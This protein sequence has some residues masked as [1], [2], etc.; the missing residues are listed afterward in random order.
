MITSGDFLAGG[1]GVTE[2]MHQIPNLQCRWVLN[3]DQLAIKTN[4]FNHK[5]VKHFWADLYTQD[6]HEMDSV[7]FVWASIECTQHSKANGGREKKLGSFMLGWELLRYLKFIKPMCIVIENV[8]EFKDWGPVDS[9]GKP[10][11]SMRGAEF[12][13]W[14][15]SICNLGYEY[16]E[17]IMNAADY[18]I[19]TRRVR[20]FCFFIRKDLGISARWPVQTHSKKGDNGFQKWEA[21]RQYIDLDNQ[22]QSI[23]GREFNLKVK[24]KKKLSHNTLR[25]IA[26]GIKKYSPE[27]YFILHYN[28]SGNVGQS[29]SAPLNT[30]MT[31]DRHALISLEKIQFIQDYCRGDIFNHVQDPMS[32]QLTRQTKHLITAQFI[33]KQYNSNDNPAVNNQGLDEP[34]GS[35]TTQEKMQFISAYFNSSNHPETQNQDI[36]SP[37]N[38]ILTATNKKALV[39]VEGCNFDFDIKMRFLDPEELSRVSTFPESYFTNPELKISKKDQ[40]K[41]IGNAVPPQWAKI[42]I[43][44]MVRELEKVK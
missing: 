27:M 14:V 11:K 35:L 12:R 40:V 22:G 7:D 2:A 44:P 23:F 10:I 6:E 4:V 34:L 39:T 30:I 8:P 24:R 17:R 42:I 15:D 43:E 38:T 36:D 18:G 32:P 31:K 9:E 29:L 21:C 37:L 3:H 20:F 25:R 16:H 1:G 19:P 41:L 28:G 13:K 26:G 5:N 33:S